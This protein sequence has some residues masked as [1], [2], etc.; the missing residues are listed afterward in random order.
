M[1]KNIFHNYPKSIFSIV[2]IINL[3]F[4]YCTKGGKV[5]IISVVTPAGT[6]GLNGCISDIISLNNRNKI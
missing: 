4:Q 6:K 5:T 3:K 1:I 2:R